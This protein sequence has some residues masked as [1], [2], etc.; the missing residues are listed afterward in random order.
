MM[1]NVREPK[2]ISHTP[3]RELIPSIQVFRKA[4][5]TYGRHL[6]ISFRYISPLYF[7][8]ILFNPNYPEKI[9]KSGDKEYNP[10]FHRENNRKKPGLFT[11]NIYY[12]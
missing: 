4:T 1:T 10:N 12:N 3:R 6:H 8:Q 9:P 5:Y 7:Y 11:G 2:N